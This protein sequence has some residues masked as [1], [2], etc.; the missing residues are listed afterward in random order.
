MPSAACQAQQSA[1]RVA[2][3]Q[4]K[5][6]QALFTTAAL[7]QFRQVRQSSLQVLT[8]AAPAL[9]QLPEAAAV[10]RQ[11]L[12]A[13]PRTVRILR[14]AAVTLAM[15]VLAV[16]VPSAVAPAEAQEVRLMAVQALLVAR[17]VESR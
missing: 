4:G 16:A 8:K 1:A 5:A 13:V 2:A 9:L 3:A 15:A 12:P 6:R 17:Q 7:R 14:E 11:A 10:L